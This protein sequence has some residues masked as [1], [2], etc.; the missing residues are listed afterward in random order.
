MEINR[1]DFAQEMMLRKTIR[2]GIKVIAE[3]K[4]LQILEEKKQEEQLR[5]IIRDLIFEATAV[6]D[7]DPAP[8]KAT[9]INVLEDLLKKII[10]VL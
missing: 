8:H 2:K 5:T 7:N 4:K 6:A 9:G 3:R 10:P 1:L